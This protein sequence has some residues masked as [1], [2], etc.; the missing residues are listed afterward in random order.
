MSGRKKRLDPR[1]HVRRA[2]HQSSL[3]QGDFAAAAGL[4]DDDSIEDDLD[5]ICPV[6][7]GDCT[8]SN[9]PSRS[10]ARGV[11]KAKANHQ[12]SRTQ[13]YHR[14]LSTRV[15][16]QII[17]QKASAA[18]LESPSDASETETDEDI[19]PP[20][21]SAVR[22]LAPTDPKVIVRLGLSPNI[23]SKKGVPPALGPTRP[24][25]Y[26][27][28]ERTT[29]KSSRKRG[30]A[31]K[32]TGAT[33]RIPRG[34]A[35]DSGTESNEDGRTTTRKTFLDGDESELTE[36]S[37]PD[38]DDFDSGDDRD[39][40]AEEEAML[41]A[42][43][44]G[45]LSDDDIEANYADDDIISDNMS[46]VLEREADMMDL[47]YLGADLEEEEDFFA[48]IDSGFDYS[49]EPAPVSWQSTSEEDIEEEMYFEHLDDAPVMT[50]SDINQPYM[51]NIDLLTLQQEE[52]DDEET[53]DDEAFGN[54][55]VNSNGSSSNEATAMIDM[56]AL[57][58]D[59][60]LVISQMAQVL[61]IPVAAAAQMLASID[62]SALGVN[63]TP[64]PT[65]PHLAPPAILTPVSTSTTA[66][67]PTATPTPNGRG[68]PRGPVM[69][70]WSQSKNGPARSGFSTPAT[71][72]PLAGRLPSRPTPTAT[73]LGTPL[74][75]RELELGSG[76]NTD[77]GSP[78]KRI[79]TEPDTEAIVKEDDSDEETSSGTDIAS[80]RS[81]PEHEPSPIPIDEL[82]DT[83]TFEN[84]NDSDE[85]DDD[86]S[87]EA[88]R[89]L[90][91]LDRWERVP[92]GAFRRSRH[93]S[94][95]ISVLELAAASALRSGASPAT[96]GLGSNDRP[97]RPKYAITTSTTGSPI[98]TARRSSRAAHAAAQ[99][100]QLAQFSSFDGMDLNDLDVSISLLGGAPPSSV[101]SSPL[102]SP[103]FSVNSGRGPM[104]PPLS[105]T[106][107]FDHGINPSP[108][109]SGRRKDHTSLLK[110]SLPSPRMPHSAA[111]VLFAE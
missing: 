6:C 71:A 68:P 97:R 37:S 46:D 56:E 1:Q 98:L 66:T 102:Q 3:D 60:V 110:K 107:E 49:I 72:S 106:D 90:E 65:V 8:C 104:P 95:Q 70:A 74:G 16:P 9:R 87:E 101:I 55:H 38:D 83:Q 14:P 4:F 40:E 64:E 44:N 69:G 54:N 93:P 30:V 32:Y 42:E 82:V 86:L 108:P 80:P 18:V 23:G 11:L 34:A 58:T 103:L 39:I 5:D 22:H 111:S 29:R 28:Y 85:L 81:E 45:N 79:K 76:S 59:P 99:Q 48:G 12:P 7:V 33:P 105:L 47:P 27:E 24:K 15:T 25:K 41:I 75:K 43:A 88:S 10:F 52:D 21:R 94:G 17:N 20:A 61:N 50:I 78:A 89:Y 31:E 67:R 96:L 36:F 53:T 57:A 13:P 109:S 63:G 35:S 77:D 51:N 84:S 19:R 91:H 92:I 62:V 100:A 73:P 26:N 2:Q